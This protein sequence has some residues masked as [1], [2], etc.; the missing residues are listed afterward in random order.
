MSS[1]VHQCLVCTSGSMV[2]IQRHKGIPKESDLMGKRKGVEYNNN[3][4]LPCH[5]LNKISVIKCT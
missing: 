2:S 4:V 3:G 5:L 1:L